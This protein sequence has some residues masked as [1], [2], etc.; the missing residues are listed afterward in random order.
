MKMRIVKMYRLPDTGSLRA[1]FDIEFEG[2][3]TV[4]GFRIMSGKHGLF[5]SAPR[6][7]ARDGRR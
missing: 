1:F 5:I 3:L 4:R 6:E 2:I 7:V